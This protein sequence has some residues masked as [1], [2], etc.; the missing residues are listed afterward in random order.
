MTLMSEMTDA[1]LSEVYGYT[2]TIDASSYLMS[3]VT[4]TDLS[5]TVADGTGFSRGIAQIDEELLILDAADRG[6]GLL[7]CGHVSSRGVRG[8]TAATHAAGARMTMSPSIPRHQAV[9]AVEHT[10]RSSNGLYATDSHS[11][12]Y[13]AATAGYELPSDVDT[14]LAVTWLPPEVANGYIQISRYKHD[15]FNNQI[16]L[17][18][19]VLP[20]EEVTVY[21]TKEPTV[22]AQSEDF[23][24]SGL[25]ASCEDVIRYGAAWRLMSFLE[26]MSLLGQSSEA[27]AM[28]SVNTP[29]ARLKVS[30]YFF[31]MYRQRLDEEVMELNTN[32][33]TSVHFGG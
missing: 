14:I 11:F 16:I 22:P 9:R 21:Y 31:Q 33:P 25:P 20:G 32:Y 4:A 8:T 10:I 28:D 29:A 13:S 12:D 24:T 7:T 19:G 26:P 3:A 17:R 27:D 30:Q 2:S 15:R 6:V 18:Q 5:F 23:S 1:V